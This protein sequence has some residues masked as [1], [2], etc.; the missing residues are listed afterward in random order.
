MD[1]SP[2][3]TI[4]SHAKSHTPL[5]KIWF[6]P[7]LKREFTESQQVLQDILGHP[8]VHFSYPYGS[9][10]KKVDGLVRQYYQ[11]AAAVASVKGEPDVYCC[12]DDDYIL[13]RIHIKQGDKPLIKA[14]KPQR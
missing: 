4:G 9:Y 13:P 6:G 12:G 10:C 3:C 2:L 7:F 11:S 8:V 14:K 1:Q 5:N